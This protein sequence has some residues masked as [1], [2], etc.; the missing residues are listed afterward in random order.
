M[1]VLEDQLKEVANKLNAA[2]NV[3]TAEKR[4]H[5]GN[6]LAWGALDALDDLQEIIDTMNEEEDDAG[7]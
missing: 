3:Y 5:P 4:R 7:Y 2:L 1:P 6:V